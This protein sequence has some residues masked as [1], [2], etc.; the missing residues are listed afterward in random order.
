MPSTTSQTQKRYEVIS[1]DT[2]NGGNDAITMPVSWE[3]PVTNN[4]G[5]HKG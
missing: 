1:A 3:G 5:S 4:E 2:M